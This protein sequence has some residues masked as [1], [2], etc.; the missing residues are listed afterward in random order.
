MDGR[1]RIVT[2]SSWGE[3]RLKTQTRSKTEVRSK[4]KVR[5]KTQGERN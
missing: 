3:V 5:L 2:T 4:T 1:L